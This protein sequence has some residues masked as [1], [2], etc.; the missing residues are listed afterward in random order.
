MSSLTNV[1]Q[2]TAVK[3]KTARPKI[4]AMVTEVVHF[5]VNVQKECQKV[6]SPHNAF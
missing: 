3:L 1:H 5:V 2:D 6:C 4:V